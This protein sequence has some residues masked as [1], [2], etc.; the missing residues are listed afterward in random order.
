MQRNQGEWRAAFTHVGY[1]E[2]TLSN[3][4]TLFQPSLSPQGSAKRPDEARILAYWRDW[5]LDL[6]GTLSSDG[7][8]LIAIRPVAGGR[9]VVG[10]SGRGTRILA[11]ATV[12]MY[13]IFLKAF[14]FI[15]R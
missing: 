2:M 8:I 4:A 6:P 11:A 3:I 5:L 12:N 7:Q 1:T 14:A 15:S 9:G 10:W 13:Y